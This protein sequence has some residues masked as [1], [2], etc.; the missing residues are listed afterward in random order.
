MPK[1]R[2]PDRAGRGLKYIRNRA[3]GAALVYERTH[4]RDPKDVSNSR[5]GYDIVSGDRKIEVKGQGAPWKKIK[6]ESVHLTENEL[7]NATHL[8]IVCNV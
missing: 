7:Q 4:G 1:S 2:G 5:Q 8:Y 3:M 6:S